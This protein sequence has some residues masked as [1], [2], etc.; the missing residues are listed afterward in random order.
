ITEGARYGGELVGHRH[1]HERHQRVGARHWWSAA[2][3]EQRRKPTPR[4]GNGPCA[5]APRLVKPMTATAIVDAVGGHGGTGTPR[6]SAAAICPAVDADAAE[7]R[8]STARF[9]PGRVA[10]SQERC[11]ANPPA[12]VAALGGGHGRSSGSPRARA[13]RPALVFQRA[14][15]LAS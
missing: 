4:S 10:G 3:R 14:S 6:S 2:A 7:P 1:Q 5:G 15:L 11:V 8:A 9:R 12:P 13:A